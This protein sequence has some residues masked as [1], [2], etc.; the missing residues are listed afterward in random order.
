MMGKRKEKKRKREELLLA[1]CRNRHTLYCTVALL[2]EYNPLLLQYL[3]IYIS[4]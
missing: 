4:I 2:Y 3:S 1:S